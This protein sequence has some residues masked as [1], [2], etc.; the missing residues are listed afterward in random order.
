MKFE[1]IIEIN[2]P[3]NHNIPSLSIEQLWQGLV[4][5]AKSPKLFI[6]HLDECH[7]L[8]TAE[9]TVSRVSHYGN[10]TVHDTVTFAPQQHVHYHVPVQGEVPA[11]TLKMTI[12]SPQ[13][14]VLLVRFVYE[15]NKSDAENAADKMYD[16]FRKSAYHEADIDTIRIIRELALEGRFDTPLV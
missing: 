10:L 16:D 12:E 6:P 11:S 13:H 7:V 2:N 15:D 8:E 4:L 5:R 9:N 14:D 3:N 1:H